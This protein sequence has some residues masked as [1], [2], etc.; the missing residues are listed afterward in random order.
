MSQVEEVDIKKLVE[1]KLAFDLKNVQYLNIFLDYDGTLVNIPEIDPVNATLTNE[2][3]SALDELF[4]KAKACKSLQVNIFLITGRDSDQGAE[5]LGKYDI[6]VAGCHGYD[7]KKYSV[8]SQGYENVEI[9]NIGKDYVDDFDTLHK[10]LENELKKTKFIDDKI[11]M[12]YVDIQVKQIGS[13]VFTKRIRHYIEA[14]PASKEEKVKLERKYCGMVLKIMEKIIKTNSLRLS[15][16]PGNGLYE[17]SPDFDWNK[18][19]ALIWLAEYVHN[20]SNYTDSTLKIKNHNVVDELMRN[21][22]VEEWK[23][24][25]TICLGDELSDE[26]AFKELKKIYGQDHMRSENYEAILVRGLLQMTNKQEKL[27]K[28]KTFANYRLMSVELVE[29]YLRKLSEYI[30]DLD[31]RN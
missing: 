6:L 15:M 19:K 3:K 26:P 13:S 23:R 17:V 20:G 14:S 12:D 27:R 18:G 11:L 4:S 22:N 29:K 5:K 10:N 21:F 7:I 28:S 16:V 25:I 1:P 31:K 24:T 30:V 8:T 2:M 9:K